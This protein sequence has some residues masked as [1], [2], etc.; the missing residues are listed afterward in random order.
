VLLQWREKAGE[1]PPTCSQSKLPT[2]TQIHT[3]T[4]TQTIFTPTPTFSPLHPSTPTPTHLPTYLPTH[5]RIHLNTRACIWANTHTHTQNTYSC[6]RTV[7]LSQAPICVCA[8]AT[9]HMHH[10]REKMM[11][12]R[13]KSMSTR[14]TPCMHAP[15]GVQTRSAAWNVPGIAPYCSEGMLRPYDQC[16]VQQESTDYPL[17]A[18]LWYT[19]ETGERLNSRAQTAHNK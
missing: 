9:S 1:T 3:H 10:S 11:P 15:S 7:N 6:T 14:S 19:T 5:T 8:C 2:P 18:A 12:R 17:Q 16:R 13:S 4:N